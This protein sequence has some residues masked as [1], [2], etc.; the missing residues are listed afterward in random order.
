METSIFFITFWIMTCKFSKYLFK[1]DPVLICQSKCIKYVPYF[2]D[3]FNNVYNSALNCYYLSK[4]Y[5][6]FKAVV[7]Q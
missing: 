7:L 1:F 6:Y 3:V 2:Y 4:F 5:F